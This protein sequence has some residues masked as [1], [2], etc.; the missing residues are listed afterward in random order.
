M[1]MAC[2]Q[3]QLYT[4]GKHEEANK[5]ES[6]TVPAHKGVLSIFKLHISENF[7]A[8]TLKFLSVNTDQK[9]KRSACLALHAR[10]ICSVSISHVS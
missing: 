1:N 4:T 3:F 7:V 8:S 6:G 5:L 2:F 10:H 9:D